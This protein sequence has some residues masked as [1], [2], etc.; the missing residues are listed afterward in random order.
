MRPDARVVA[1]EG[2]E[3]SRQRRGSALANEL[4]LIRPTMRVLYTSGFTN[5]AVAEQGVAV[6]E[7]VFLAKP[8]SSASLAAKMLEVLELA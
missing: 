2:L 7:T 3:E 1:P 8:F 5:S 6:E 4:S